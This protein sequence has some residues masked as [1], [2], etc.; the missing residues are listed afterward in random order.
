MAND[1][2]GQMC[3]LGQPTPFPAVTVPAMAYVPFQQFNTIYTPEQ[4]FD[5]GTIFPDLNKPFYGRRGEPR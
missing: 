5:N 3:D 2:N 4:G 1:M